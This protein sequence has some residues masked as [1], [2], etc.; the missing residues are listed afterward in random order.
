VNGKF[1]SE[2][3]FPCTRA[4]GPPRSQAAKDAVITVPNDRWYIILHAAWSRAKILGL[5]RGA[6]DHADRTCE[7]A[8]R[9]SDESKSPRDPCGRRGGGPGILALMTD[10]QGGEPLGD[11]LRARTQRRRYFRWISTSPTSYVV[12]LNGPRT[13]RRKPNCKPKWNFG[14]SNA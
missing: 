7:N 9:K 10:A 14:C 3:L 6:R 12:R 5:H 2:S 4:R 13:E 11:R 1:R 8:G